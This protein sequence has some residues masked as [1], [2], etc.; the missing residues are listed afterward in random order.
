MNTVVLSGW[1]PG[2]N[3]VELTKLLQSSASLSLSEAK[4]RI[5]RLIDGDPI[6]VLFEQPSEAEHFGAQATELGAIVR[7]EIAR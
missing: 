5:D 3:K 1:E 7:V 4:S 2:L 6:E